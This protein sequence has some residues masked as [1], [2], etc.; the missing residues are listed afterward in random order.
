MINW[1]IGGIILG[2][3]AFI[4][5]KTVIRL[6]KGEGCCCENTKACSQCNY[7]HER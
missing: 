6:K 5:V 1:I 2:A 3:A 7:K 4:I